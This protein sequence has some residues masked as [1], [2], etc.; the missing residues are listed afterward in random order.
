MNDL[1]TAEPGANDEIKK[2]VVEKEE[3][4]AEELDQVSGGTLILQGAQQNH[5]QTCTF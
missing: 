1:K 2:Q 5:N 3:L 4:A